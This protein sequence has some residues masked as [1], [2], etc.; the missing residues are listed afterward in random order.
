VLVDAGSSGA[1]KS[2]LRIAFVAINRIRL[3]ARVPEELQ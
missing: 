1:R 3:N 2:L